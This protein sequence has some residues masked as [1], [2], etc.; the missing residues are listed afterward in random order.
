MLGPGIASRLG[1]RKYENKN[2]AL[3]R[4]IGTE[5]AENPR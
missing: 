1:M 2:E 5:K 3:I 4:S